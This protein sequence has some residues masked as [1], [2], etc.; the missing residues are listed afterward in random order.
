MNYNISITK[1]I[2]YR[3]CSKR[4]MVL[5]CANNFIVDLEQCLN[6]DYVTFKNTFNNI[7][8]KVTDLLCNN[9]GVQLL[10]FINYNGVECVQSKADALLKCYNNIYGSKETNEIS[11]STLPGVRDECRLAKYFNLTH[12][13][14]V[15][16]NQSPNQ[17]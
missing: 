2:V 11:D 13:Y 7:T 8:V 17:Q 10:V 15:C 12:F 9:H 5:E 3:Y 1:L 4:S 16:K 6:G 14:F